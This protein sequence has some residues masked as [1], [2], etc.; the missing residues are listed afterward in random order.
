MK[1]FLYPALA[2]LAISSICQAQTKATWVEEFRMHYGSTGLSVLYADKSGEYLEETHDAHHMGF[3]GVGSRPSSSIVKLTPALTEVYHNDFDKELRGKEFQRFLFINNKLYLFAS[4][5]TQRGENTML[6]ASEVDK[7]TGHLKQE[8]QYIYQWKKAE[9]AE[10]LVFKIVPNYDSTRLILTATYEGK[11]TNRYELQTLDEDL[12]PMGDPMV[13]TNEFDPKTFVVE[14]FV[15]TP[16]GNEVVVG[17]TYEYAEGR[18]KRD[19]NLEFKSYNIRIYD[20]KGQQIKEL[21]TDVG[22]KYY[23]TSKVMQI[24][25]EL[26]LAA[27]YCNSRDRKEING[28]LVQRIDPATGNI[29]MSAQKEISAASITLVEDDDDDKKEVKPKGDNDDGLGANLRFNKFYFTPDNGLIILAEKTKRWMS[30]STTPAGGSGMGTLQTTTTEA[31]YECGDVYISKISAQGNIDWLHVIP[32]NQ[33]E[34]VVLGESMGFT[35]GFSI[36]TDYYFSNSWSY[37]LFAGVGSI[38][39]KT[40]LHLFFNDYQKNADVLEPGKHIKRVFTFGRTSCYEVTLDM[41]T[42]KYTKKEL[43]SNKDIPNAMPR[44]GIE[45]DK[46]LYMTGKESGFMG[47]THI[48]VGKLV[49]K[50]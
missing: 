30:Y 11:G 16:N 47:K 9:H 28:L 32:K 38:S 42:G 4:D 49:C 39:G 23:V 10:K 5:N 25:N 40:N 15:C 48:A 50:D 21:A 12:K 34:T 24:R 43:F 35:Y 44:L 37:P 20:P 3:F 22:N 36:T 8:W 27:Y 41:I 2:C 1:P 29:L 26:V 6:F 17:R 19:K 13:I 45:W 31:H 46:C 33:V 14:D 18:S 7:N